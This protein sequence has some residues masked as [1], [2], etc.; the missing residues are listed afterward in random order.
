MPP[1]KILLVRHAEKPV[2][3]PPFG[4]TADGVQDNHSLIVRGWQ[5]AGA[6]APFFTSPNLAGGVTTPG[7]IYASGTGGASLLVDEEDVSKSLR[8]QQTVTPTAEK[9]IITPITRFFVGQEAALA[10]DIRTRAGVVLVGWEHTHIPMIPSALKSNAP[11]SW[12]DDRFDVVWI[13]DYQPKTDTYAF[14]QV[15][16]S[17]LSGDA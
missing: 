13:L 8:P 11:N 10:T 6:L 16:Q 9:L 7:T 15:N 3:E 14:T 5:R 17:L 12:P 2:V 4:I 1:T